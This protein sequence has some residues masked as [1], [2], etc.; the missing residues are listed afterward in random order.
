MI[1]TLQPIRHYLHAAMVAIILIS[2]APALH[3]KEE[4]RTCPMGREYFLYT[5]DTIDA[6]KTYWLVVGVHGYRG[7]GKG[8]GRLS[9]WIK[10]GN[11]IVVGPS[12]P[13]EGYQGLAKESDKQL[14]DIFNLLRKEFRLQPKL[15]ISGFSGGSQYSHRFALTHPELVIGCASHSGGTWADSLNAKAIKVPFAISCG[16]NDTGK[17]VPEAPFSRIDW[18]K[19]FV[20]KMNDAPFYFKARTWPGVSHSASSGSAGMTEECF[21]LST[22]GMHTEALQSLTAEIR[23]VEEDLTANR[24][25]EA[26]ARVRKLSNPGGTGAPTRTWTNKDGSK[27]FEG[28][29]KSYDPATGEVSV[30]QANGTMIKFNQDK[31]SPEDITFLKQQ[32]KPNPPS[33]NS[34]TKDKGD[35]DKTGGNPLAGIQED[36]YGWRVS[37]AGKAALDEVR[38]AFIKQ[39]SDELNARIAASASAKPR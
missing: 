35:V 19:S 11:V 10:K 28:Q 25:S 21:N 14:I 33:A 13:N 16:E 27:T 22:T 24:L 30:T 9:D 8:A 6:N 12:F 29:L 39:T 15:F 1:K 23:K 32:G 7:N 3:A 31:L 18:F 17:T 26:S 38:Q 4:K 37:P 34:P 5:P 36:P 2:T 20:G